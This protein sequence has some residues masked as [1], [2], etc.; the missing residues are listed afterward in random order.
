MFFFFGDLAKF[1]YNMRFKGVLR[2]FEQTRVIL[3][4]LG[5]I[6]CDF[7]PKRSHMDPFRLKYYEICAFTVCQLGVSG[8]QEGVYSLKR[9]DKKNNQKE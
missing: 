1:L 4:T 6:V 9:E 5:S 8:S 7:Q 2:D 3:D